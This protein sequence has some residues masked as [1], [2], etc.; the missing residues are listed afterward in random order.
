EQERQEEAQKERTRREGQEFSRLVSQSQ[1]KTSESKSQLEQAQHRDASQRSAAGEALLARHGI[2]S[3]HFAAKLQT[4]GKDSGEKERVQRGGREVESR[5]NRRVGDE[6]NAESDRRVE[7]REQQQQNDR[8]AAISRDDPRGQKGG[9]G[10]GDLG[11]DAGA[12]GQLAGQGNIAQPAQAVA[13]SEAK[14]AA[15]A[16]LPQHV[17]DEIVKR[18]L[19][20]VNAQ[21]ISEFQIEFRENVLAGSRLFISAEGGKISARFETPDANVKRL[22]KASEG[23]LARAFGRKGLSLE[24]FEVTGP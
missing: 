1:Q 13:A 10:G 23:E 8:L 22:L 2:Q 6:K 14:G 21:G 5:D 12:E 24:R 18:V 17:L 11:G 4:Q 7:T 9:G 19:V 20:G 16:R 15:G 3:R